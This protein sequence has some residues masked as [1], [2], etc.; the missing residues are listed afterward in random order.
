M[1]LWSN[2][3]VRMQALMEAGA[4][5]SVVE[6]LAQGHKINAIKACRMETGLGLKEAKEVV[7]RYERLLYRYEP[8]N[9]R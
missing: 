7:D 9:T 1:E 2:D 5:H 4:S 3:A 8:W 6:E